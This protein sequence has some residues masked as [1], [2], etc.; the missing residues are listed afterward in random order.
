M[1]YF[2]NDLKNCNNVMTNK[3]ALYPSALVLNDEDHISVGVEVSSLIKRL[4]INGDEDPT[5]KIYVGY[6]G[7]SN[8]NQ[9]MRKYLQLYRIR[10]INQ[11]NCCQGGWDLARMVNNHKEYWDLVKKKIVGKD[12]NNPKV[13]FEQIQVWFFK[14]S[15]AKPRGGVHLSFDKHVAE[16]ERLQMLYIEQVMDHFPNLK[17]I[18]LSSGTYSFYGQVSAPRNEPNTW[19]EGVAI[20][21]I[22][23]KFRTTTGP[24]IAWGPYLWT[25]GVVGRSGDGLKWTCYDVDDDGVH[26]SLFGELKVAA[27]MKLFMDQHPAAAFAR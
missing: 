1:Y 21:N 15:L 7:M 11:L 9:E 2:G 26:P 10:M 23:G 3:V 20:D 17:M 25:N 14:N 5:G 8:Y 6:S 16:F 13:S 24:W 22:V 27:M 4:N 19:G 12:P 18:L